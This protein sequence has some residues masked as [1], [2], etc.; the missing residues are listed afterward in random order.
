MAPIA[1]PFRAL[2]E[3]RLN[4][5][6]A[7]QNSTVVIRLPTLGA[8]TWSKPIQKRHQVIETPVADDAEAFRHRQLATA[9]SIYHRQFYKSPRSFLW[10]V[11]EG[12]KVLSIRAVDISRP[13]SAADANITL[14]LVF[15]DS[16]IRSGCV[17]FADSDQHD[18][19]SAFVLLENNNFYTLTLRPDFFRKAASTEDN[20]GD[21]CKVIIPTA[22]ST[23]QIPHRLAALS[24]DEVL[25][26]NYD[27][28]LCRLVKSSGSDGK[29]LAS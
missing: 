11:L 26:A 18:I 2:K 6:P 7:T 14:R 21:W 20:V 12:G 5:D 19:L 24:A 17:A 23:K 15:F 25:I 29:P 1:P 28:G 22:Y 4:L 13:T 10:R 8:S 9:S 27:G 3:T 16:A